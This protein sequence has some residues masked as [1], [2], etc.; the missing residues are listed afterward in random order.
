M[1][2]RVIVCGSRNWSDRNIIADKL[3]D[4]V[5]A[6]GW[7]FPDPII[8]HGAAR[9]VDRLAGEEAEKAGLLV[10]VHPAQ[11]DKYGNAAGLKRNEKMA[12]LG[13]DL[14]VAFW[15]GQSTG[16]KHM[17]DTAL[18]HGIPVIQVMKCV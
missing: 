5:L 13:A 3:N 1:S 4:L 10:E 15:D 9:G 11:W 18:A 12:K 7:R 16:T 14:C 6:R 8:V 2:V 17:M